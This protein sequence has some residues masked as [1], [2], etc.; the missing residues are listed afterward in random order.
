M[1][2]LSFNTPRGRCLRI[3]CLG[4]HSD[5]IEIGCGG[6]ILTLLRGY[7]NV[8]V[9]W[10]VYSGGPVR[11]REAR[12]SAALFLKRTLH[13]MVTVHDFRESF[14]PYL[15]Q[16]KEAFERLKEEYSPDL[17][18]THFREDLHQDHRTVSDLTWST[19]RNHMILEYEIPKYDGDLGKPNC[20][21]ELDS[22]TCERKIRYL[23]QCFGSQQNR[24]WFTAE[25]FQALHR[26]RGIECRAPGQYAEGFYCRKVVLSDDGGRGVHGDFAKP[27]Q[28]SSIR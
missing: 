19:F 15:G 17:V 8:E 3:L 5:D 24:Q 7:R 27:D 23:I 11:E 22:A 4:A 16:L 13:Q 1:M 21:V 6:T 12:R 10:V 2:N 9:R 14:F 20:Y 25:T 28:E 18:F 26:L